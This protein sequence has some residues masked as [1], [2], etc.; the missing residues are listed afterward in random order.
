MTATS[1]ITVTINGESRETEDQILIPAF[2]KN[3]GL[4]PDKVIVEWN[5]QAQ[6]RAESA[7]TALSDGDRLEAVR[8]V[9]GG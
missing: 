1:S 7:I 9:A 6:T 2:L 4:Q 3:C 8:L 5:G